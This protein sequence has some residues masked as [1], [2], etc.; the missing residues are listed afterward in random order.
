MEDQQTPT[1]PPTAESQEQAQKKP[2]KQ[3]TPV[4]AYVVLGI[5]LIGGFLA[6]YAWWNEIWWA[7]NEFR[8]GP[9]IVLE[10]SDLELGRD[11]TGQVVKGAVRNDTNEKYR[12]VQVAFNLYGADGNLL[13]TEVDSTEVLE[14]GK[15]W[16]FAATTLFD[17]AV[18]AELKEVT[19]FLSDD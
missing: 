8:P 15:T 2:S 13:G 10:V 7:S 9:V 6:A 5:V 4:S 12:D 18:R 19:G 16:E 3:Q 1:S 14:A 11:L 17:S